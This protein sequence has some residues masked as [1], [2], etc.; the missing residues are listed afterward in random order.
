M[1]WSSRTGSRP[2]LAVAAVV[3]SLAAAG[4]G[5]SSTG[6]KSASAGGGSGQSK[7]YVNALKFSRCMRS[8]GVSQFPDPHNPGGW[9]SGAIDALNTST[10][11][12]SS[13]TATCDKLLPNEGQPTSADFEQ[14]VV[15]GVKVAK[16]MR[17][18]GVYMPDPGVDGNHLTIDMSHMSA[19]ETTTPKFKRV[20]ALCQKKVFGY[21]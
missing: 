20:G 11:A 17:A 19:N 8:H 10:P 18:H 12:F 14:T 9:S 21:A 5:G 4:C 1:A 7:Q 2:L 15:N 13:A 6:T 3:V 16:C